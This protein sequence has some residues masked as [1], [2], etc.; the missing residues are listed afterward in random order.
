M[1]NMVPGLL[2][3]AESVSGEGVMI[4]IIVKVNSD[5]VI[6]VKETLAAYLE[7][8][9]DCHVVEVREEDLHQMKIGEKEL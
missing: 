1:E 2:E 6:G 8:F 7:R 5:D 3:S 4:T 9:G